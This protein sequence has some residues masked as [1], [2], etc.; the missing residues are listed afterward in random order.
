MTNKTLPSTINNYL[1]SP[2][3]NVLSPIMKMSIISN[4]ICVMKRENEVSL[5][6]VS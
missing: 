6:S 4:L 5:L 1:A 2:F 3:L